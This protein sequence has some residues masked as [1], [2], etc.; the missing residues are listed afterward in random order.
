[1]RRLRS[2]ASP[3]P[4]PSLGD[5]E[6]ARLERV[7]QVEA[8]VGEGLE[9]LDRRQRVDLARQALVGIAHELLE[10]VDLGAAAG[11][12]ERERGG[13]KQT[14]HYLP[15]ALAFGGLVLGRLALL[16]DLF[17]VE[18][19]VGLGHRFHGERCPSLRR[20]EL[21]V[22]EQHDARHLRHV[23]REGAEVVV[24]AGHL[25]VDRQL[26]V[27]LGEVLLLRSA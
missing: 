25:E 18:V 26:R 3:P 10:L 6:L 1:M 14:L 17:L 19:A 15:P 16:G 21:E 12:H 11:E 2:G 27:E 20:I 23:A 5:G 9:R 4:P 13:Q 8:F 22:G 24:V 7:G